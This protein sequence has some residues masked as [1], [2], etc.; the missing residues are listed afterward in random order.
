MERLMI[1]LTFCVIMICGCPPPT[2][3]VT[4]EHLP[5]GSLLA[6]GQPLALTLLSS[7]ANGAAG[8]GDPSFCRR[9]ILAIRE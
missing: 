5:R 6:L 1:F 9:L 8:T 2:R 3:T 7:R 4:L